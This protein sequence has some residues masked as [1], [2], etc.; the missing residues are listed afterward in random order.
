MTEE[1]QDTWQEFLAAVAKKTKSKATDIIN[2]STALN[3]AMFRPTIYLL[4]GIHGN[5]LFSDSGYCEFDDPAKVWEHLQHWAGMAARSKGAPSTWQDCFPVGF[6]IGIFS[7]DELAKSYPVWELLKDSGADIIN[8]LYSQ[9]YLRHACEESNVRELEV[10]LD[11]LGKHDLKARVFASS[12]HALHPQMPQLLRGFGIEFAYATTRLAGGAPTSYNP[13]VIWEGLDGTTITAIASQSGLP[14]GHV[15][16]GKFFEELPSLIFSAVARPDLPHVVYMNIEDLANPMPGSNEIASHVREFEKEHIFIRGFKDLI[17]NKIPVS[18]QVRWSIDDFPIRIMD[19][20]IIA[21]ARRCEDFL[22]LAES[23]DAL[24]ST[25]GGETHETILDNAWKNLLAAQNHDAY[26]VPFTIPGMYSD[27]QGIEKTRTWDSEETIEDR[28]VRLVNDA[29]ST[30]KSVLD[31]VTRLAQDSR[32]YGVSLPEGVP[33]LNMLWTRAEVVGGRVYELPALG[34][35]S[36]SQPVVSSR[37][38][39]LEGQSI[40]YADHEFEIGTRPFTVTHD[41]PAGILVDAGRY[42]AHLIDSGTRLEI[43]LN[44]NIPLEISIKTQKEAVI[45][46][47]FG[48]E[49]STE[50]SGH[51]LRFAWLDDE[52]VVSHKG[53]PYFKQDNGKFKIQVPAGEHSFAFDQAS[54]LLDAYQRAWEFFYPPVPFL[55]REDPLLSEKSSEP[56]YDARF[57]GTIPISYRAKYGTIFARL[58]SIDGSVPY[59]HDAV[60]VDFR[61]NE[62]EANVAPWRI[63][64]YKLPPSFK[65]DTLS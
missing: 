44:T 21:G 37:N 16:H 65:L 24:L 51:T 33:V 14:N 8:P 30:A 22:V 5:I 52:L 11:I 23:A 43:S 26:V 35:S 32:E 40:V 15:W 56:D 12:E 29:R 48:A 60:P 58:L 17:E 62:I 47:P 54:S 6:E 31:E 19:S 18:H 27:M 49:K 59:F 38:V 41:H 53:T 39:K 4:H 20:K 10:G 50:R 34:Y 45:T 36:T 64:N 9:P 57:N 25:L 3:N 1:N 42:T 2:L 55:L 46:Y 13:K 28:S 61:G 7:L 63:L